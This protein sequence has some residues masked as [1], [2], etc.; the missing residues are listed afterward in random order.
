MCVAADVEDG[1]ITLQFLQEATT[2]EEEE[3]LDAPDMGLAWGGCEGG[4]R[5]RDGL[6]RGGLLR[7]FR[8]TISRVNV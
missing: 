7:G 2:S 1:K 3:A 4:G 8:D 6:L 5:E